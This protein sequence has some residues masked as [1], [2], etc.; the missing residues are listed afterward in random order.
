MSTKLLDV[1]QASEFLKLGVSTLNKLRVHGGGPTY[2]ELGARVVYARSRTLPFKDSLTLTYDNVDMGHV[3][4]NAE[5]D[6][7]DDDHDGLT[8]L[9]GDDAGDG[10]VGI[11]DDNIDDDLLDDGTEED[12]DDG[13]EDEEADNIDGIGVS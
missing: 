13:V 10:S 1:K 11:N 2:I 6:V 12:D 7:S 9:D 3:S 8:I 5:T 4:D